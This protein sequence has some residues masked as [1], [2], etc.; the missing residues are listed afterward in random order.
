MPSRGVRVNCICPG[1]ILAPIYGQ[2]L[3]SPAEKQALLDRWARY[4]PLGHHA[5][6]EDIAY[7]ALYLA[8]DESSFVTGVTLVVDGSLT[9][10]DI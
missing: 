1:I 2:V 4:H 8:S 10:R 6:P 7:A 9:I 3:Q 5:L